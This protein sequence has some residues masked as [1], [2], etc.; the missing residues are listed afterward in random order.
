MLRLTHVRN[1]EKIEQ[2]SF[3]GSKYLN[4]SLLTYSKIK[5]S[6]FSGT[7]DATTKQ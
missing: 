3:N 7:R 6:I 1:Y 4:Y 5:T 2:I